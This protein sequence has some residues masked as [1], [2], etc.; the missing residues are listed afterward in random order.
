[1]LNAEVA[2]F[3]IVSFPFGWGSWVGTFA[4]LELGR[5]A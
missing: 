4:F 2:R 1:M 5:E 3:Y